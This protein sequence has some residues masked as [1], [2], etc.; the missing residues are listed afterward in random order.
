MAS[1]AE[2]E[3]LANAGGFAAWHAD[4]TA[5]ASP[6]STSPCLIIIASVTTQQAAH[7]RFN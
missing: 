7:S 5:H 4:S 2:L 1:M 3:E 6:A